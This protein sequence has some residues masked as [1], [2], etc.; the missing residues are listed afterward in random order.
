MSTVKRAAALAATLAATAAL[1]LA[2]P[3]AAGAA[4][5]G[6]NSNAS[7]SGVQ[8]V[9]AGGGELDCAS[10]NVCLYT[11]FNGGGTR[12]DLYYYKTY[13]LNGWNGVGS[14]VNNQTGQAYAKITDRNGNLLTG[15]YA[16]SA[17]ASY[18][19]A[20]AWYVT[21]CPSAC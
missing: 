1:A 20:P 9:P 11:G 4:P 13:S 5:T 17:W 6:D 12:F 21:L 10:G 19:F 14:W 3:A 7:V 2:A 15:S 8:S 18:D 16:P